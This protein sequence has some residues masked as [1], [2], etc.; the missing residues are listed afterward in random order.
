[1]TDTIA[2]DLDLEKDYPSIPLA[3][4]VAIRSSLQIIDRVNL[5][6]KRI[7][8]LSLTGNLATIA[9]ILVASSGGGPLISGWFKIGIVMYLMASTIVAVSRFIGGVTI[10]HPGK[11]FKTELDKS[12]I[13]FQKDYIY[14]AGEHFTKTNR[15]ILLR[16]NLVGFAI[17]LY[18][19]EVVFISIWFYLY[20]G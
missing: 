8:N 2:N 7:E 10:P 9:I 12:P 16:H 4:D 13:E 11:M 1:M 5:Q 19:F 14:F 6:E 17:I 15:T 20:F 3:Y 18:G